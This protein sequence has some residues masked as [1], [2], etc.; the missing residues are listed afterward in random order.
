MAIPAALLAAIDGMYPGP[1]GAG[2]L[3]QHGVVEQAV[4]E[5]VAA[6][7]LDHLV[8][9]PGFI[10]GSQAGLH[11]RH[12]Q[13]DD[14]GEVGDVELRADHR[15]GRQGAPASAVEAAQPLPDHAGDGLRT[16]RRCDRRRRHAAGCGQTRTETSSLM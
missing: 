12:G 1:F 6:G 9:Q 11:R 10:G 4:A 5:P 8:Q 2:N 14:V 16:R 3:G 7:P 15:G 13:V